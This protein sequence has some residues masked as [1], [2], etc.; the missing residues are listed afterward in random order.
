MGEKSWTWGTRKLLNNPLLQR[1]QMILE[2]TH[3]GLPNVSRKDVAG[4]LA[5]VFK[6]Q[7]VATIIVFDLKTQ[8]GGGKTTGFALV[9]DT[10]AAAKKYEPL[11]RL[12]RFGLAKKEKT[13]RKQRKERKNRAKKLRGTEKVKGK[14]KKKTE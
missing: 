14:K 4:K 8:F 3:H 2:L 10:L 6:V 11:Y 13:M 5:K 1:K 12:A 7:D 9:Y